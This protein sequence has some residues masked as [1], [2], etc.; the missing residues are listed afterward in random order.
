M[1]SSASNPITRT[2]DYS[3]NTAHLPEWPP[4]PE[5]ASR[6]AQACLLIDRILSRQK[7]QGQA[8]GNG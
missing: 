2:A 3:G 4:K 5:V 8:E 6:V 1:I 7:E